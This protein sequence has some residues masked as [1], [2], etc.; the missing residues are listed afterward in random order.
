[1]KALLIEIIKD[2]F[3]GNYEKDI[4]ENRI[5]G[6]LRPVPVRVRC[7]RYRKN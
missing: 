3:S 6:S 7:E 1:M 2:I 5:Y 4:R